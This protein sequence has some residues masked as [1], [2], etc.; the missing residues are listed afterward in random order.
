[1]NLNP[2]AARG[3]LRVR[4]LLSATLVLVVFLGVVGESSSIMLSARVRGR[5]FL[6]GF[7]Y[8]SMR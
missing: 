3:S 1:M 4:M 2:G 6:K 8:I 7:S 5:L